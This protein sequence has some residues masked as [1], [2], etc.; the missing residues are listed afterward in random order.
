M[1][2]WSYLI[3]GLFLWG[4]VIAYFVN[5][6][7][8]RFVV[9]LWWDFSGLRFI[10]EKI[11]PPIKDSV[12]R[13][14]PA[15]F[16]IW[17]FGIF[18]LY[19]ALFGLASQRYENRIDIIENRANTIITQL[20]TPAFKK[21]ISRIPVVQNMRCPKKPD[22]MN[23]VSIIISLFSNNEE[24]KEVVDLLKEAVENW[25]DSLESVNLSTAKLQWAELS[26][27]NLYNAK[28][29]YT[30]LEGA[31]FSDSEFL[32]Y[33]GE[34]GLMMT[35]DE[36]TYMS[37]DGA[38]LEYAELTGANL[39]KAKLLNVNLT[40]AN[41]TAANLQ[42][43]N[44]KEAN[45]SMANLHRAVLIKANL[46]RVSNILS[47]S[48]CETQSLYQAELD[49]EILVTIK[50]ICPKLLEKPKSFPKWMPIYKNT[51]PPP[52]IDKS[53]IPQQKARKDVDH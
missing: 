6:K 1:F 5:E 28:L 20:S 45:L 37:G 10:W 18:G 11:R 53:Q 2:K 47:S 38:N 44:L 15:T 21:A 39:Q 40:R 24:H 42:E 25:R 9:W 35:W 32:S 30:N 36:D 33:S 48:L 17:A 34:G 13:R 22:L 51:G 27:A 50:K 19:I 3:I 4:T 29:M 41:L 7:S 23:P 31:N 14:P 43:A 16:M 8:R 26:R 52:W 46:K 12:V 49:Q